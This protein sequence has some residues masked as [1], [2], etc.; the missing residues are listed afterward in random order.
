MGVGL[1]EVDVRIL[2]RAGQPSGGNKREVAVEANAMSILV[3]K[4]L[5]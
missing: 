5:A 4:S 2:S 1:L 3:C